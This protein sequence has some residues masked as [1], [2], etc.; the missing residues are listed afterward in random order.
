MI[1]KIHSIVAVKLKSKLKY[2]NT[3]NMVTG[4]KLLTGYWHNL[5]IFNNFLKSKCE[6]IL[7]LEAEGPSP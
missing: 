4:E 1:E 7:Y 5:E 6:T 3:I 2:K